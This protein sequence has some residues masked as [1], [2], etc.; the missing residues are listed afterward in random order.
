MSVVVVTGAMIS[1]NR[2]SLIVDNRGT[3]RLA[4]K[5]MLQAIPLISSSVAGLWFR[6]KTKTSKGKQSIDTAKARSVGS[7]TERMET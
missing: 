7:S 2:S 5:I 3:A 4:M 1:L 6:S